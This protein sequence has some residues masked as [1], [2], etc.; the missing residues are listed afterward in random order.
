MSIASLVSVD[1]TQNAT[2]DQL[3]KVGIS[4]DSFPLEALNLFV[5]SSLGT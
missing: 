3:T 5:V 1:T 2:I 4:D